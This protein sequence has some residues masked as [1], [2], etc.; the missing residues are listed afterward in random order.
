MLLSLAPVA[1]MTLIDRFLTAGQHE[2]LLSDSS[3]ITMLSPRPSMRV[4]FVPTRLAMAWCTSKAGVSLSLP[5]AVV[6]TV[7][8]AVVADRSLDLDGVTLQRCVQCLDRG[9]AVLHAPGQIIEDR[10][11]LLA[12]ER[13]FLASV[14]FLRALRDPV[15]RNC[16]RK[17]RVPGHGRT[18]FLIA[19]QRPVHILRTGLQLCVAMSRLYGGTASQAMMPRIST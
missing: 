2:A 11:Q 12:Q 6:H 16:P 7:A 17:W 18:C 3:F 1:L 13:T 9:I 19:G 15:V 14:V 8:V 5:Y 4:S 10:Q